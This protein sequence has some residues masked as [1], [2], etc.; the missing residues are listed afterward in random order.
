M[1]ADTDSDPAA[2]VTYNAA[3]VCGFPEAY[4]AYTANPGVRIHW[5]APRP[6][7]DLDKCLNPNWQDWGSSSCH[8]P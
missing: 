8:K 6:F 2:N 3:F 1:D 5:E 7:Q 4:N